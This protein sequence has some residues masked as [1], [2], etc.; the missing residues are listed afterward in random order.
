MSHPNEIRL[1][2]ENRNLEKANQYL[3]AEVI[4]T[5][6][7]R[8]EARASLAAL[9]QAAQKALDQM[10]DKD[11]PRDW[12]EN[13][14]STVLADLP[15]AQEKPQAI[16]QAEIDA[17]PVGR[18]YGGTEPKPQASAEQIRVTEGGE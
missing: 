4:E 3:E 11:C 15:A 8:D 13:D 18:A 1:M 16:P 12:I 14:L 10:A 6:K 7:E 9:V 5:A 2:Q 17:L